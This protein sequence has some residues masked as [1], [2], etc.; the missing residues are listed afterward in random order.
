MDALL[1]DED[2]AFR[3]HITT[4]LT[5]AIPEHVRD[6]VRRDLE[7][8]REDIVQS[9]QALN[10]IG[11]AVPHWPQQWGGAGWTAMQRV[12]YLDQMQRLSVP[13]PLAFNADM[14]GPVLAEFGSEAQKQTYLPATANLDIWWCQG[15]SEPNAGSDLASLKCRAVREGEHY[16]INGQK[17]WTS[18]AQHA[19]MMFA[20]LRTDPDAPKK[21]MGISMIL[22]DMKS[23][24]ITVRPIKTMDGRDE[25]NEVFFDDVKVPVANLVGEEGKGWTYAKFLLESER[26]NIAGLGWVRMRL[27]RIEALARESGHWAR[28]DFR[29]RF[30]QTEIDLAGIEMLQLLALRGEQ[31]G[32]FGN[33]NTAASV[34]KIRGSQ[35]QQATTRLL[36]DVL[37]PDADA[38]AGYFTT[39]KIS[40][41]G[42]SNEIQHEILAKA[43]LRL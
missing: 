20:L 22:I 37:G 8:E 23:P 43:A 32:S 33:A 5:K 12:I 42:G 16:V 17:T 19:D 9:Q 7:L 11:L 25:V 24:G 39:R 13:T 4:Q 30:A 27:D 21:Q 41:Y 26:H 2:R 35:L 6:K 15:F 10:A 18:Y 28:Q 14:I 3:D 40:I 1:T 29:S 36:L 38:A 34:L 31:A